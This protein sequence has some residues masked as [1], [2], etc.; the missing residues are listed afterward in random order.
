MSVEIEQLLQ[1]GVHFGHQTRRWNPKMRRFIFV[2][3]GGIYI[4]DLKKTLRQLELAKECVRSTILAGNSVLFVS[5]KRQ[6]RDI[7][8]LEAERVGAYYVTER[9]LGGMLTNFQTIKK[10]IRRLKELERGEEEGAFEF[11][12]FGLDRLHELHER[13][14]PYDADVFLQPAGIH[15]AQAPP[16]SLLR[17]DIALGRI[18]TEADDG[19]DVPNVPPFLEHQNRDDCFVGT[20]GLVNF[21]GLLA[22][23]L[24]LFF[25]LA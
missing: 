22:K 7:V 25:G 4:I 14:G 8:R 20:L 9:W 13:I 19:G 11:Y 21:V 12:T 1:A 10:N 2:E 6:L 16:E 3:R 24:Q 18:G 15:L 5:T 17:Q 23:L